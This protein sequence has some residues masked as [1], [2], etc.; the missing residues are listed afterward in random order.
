MPASG[1]PSPSIYHGRR[2]WEADSMALALALALGA[3]SA[4]RHP[5]RTETFSFLASCLSAHSL[6]LSKYAFT[7]HPWTA[8]Y[9][10]MCLAELS[11]PCAI[12]P[13]AVHS[14]A[15]PINQVIGVSSDS[16][17]TLVTFRPAV[18]G[19]CD[20]NVT[21]SQASSVLWNYFWQ[22]LSRVGTCAVSDRVPSA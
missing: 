20:G 17:N 1:L 6:L 11:V 22:R 7:S 21:R 3:T 15:F 8:R 9:I 14:W 5:E 18:G 19:S 13:Q 12:G 2:Y 16:G 4:G 10:P